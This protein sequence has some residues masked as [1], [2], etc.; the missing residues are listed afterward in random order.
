M[1][2][3]GGNAVILSLFVEGEPVAKARPRVTTRNGRTWAYTP[4]KTEVAERAIRTLAKV[5][6]G[7]RVPTEAAVRLIYTAILPIPKS[8]S[9]RKQRDA[10]A[11]RIHPVS[12]PDTENLLKT[13][14]DALNG[15]CYRDD[16]QVVSVIAAKRYGTVAGVKVEVVEIA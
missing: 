16:S 9:Q 15:V 14:M 4:R 5:S 7:T 6:M 10:A 13:S 3:T 11:G 2:A 12:R 8:W 1:T